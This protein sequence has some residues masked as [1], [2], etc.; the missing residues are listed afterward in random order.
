LETFS[1]TYLWTFA[2]L[3][4]LILANYQQ[5]HID[6]PMSLVTRKPRQGNRYAY[7]YF[8]MDPT[9]STHDSPFSVEIDT[10]VRNAVNNITIRLWFQADFGTTADLQSA[11]CAAPKA[12]RQ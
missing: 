9:S 11:Y 7:Y 1:E 5:K 3:G 10:P 4:R 8:D 6:Q 2:L 12:K